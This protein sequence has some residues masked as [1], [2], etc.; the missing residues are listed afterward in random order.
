MIVYYSN[1]TAYSAAGQSLGQ[2]TLQSA[3]EMAEDWQTSTGDLVAIRLGLPP[4]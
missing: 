3:A 1:G 4:H 2:M